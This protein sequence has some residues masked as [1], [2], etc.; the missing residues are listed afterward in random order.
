MRVMV[1]GSTGWLGRYA[2]AELRSGCEVAGPPRSALDLGTASVGETAGVL[3]AFAPDAVVNCAGRVDGDPLGLAAVN[4]R[5]PAVL[6]AAMATAVP[7]A[8]LVHLGSAAEYGAVPAGE[9]VTEGTATSPQGLYGASKLT[10]TLAVAGAGLDAV[11]L[12]VFNVVGPGAP[13]TSLPG[14]LA[15]KLRAAAPGGVVRTGPLTASRDYVDPRDVARAVA[16][17]VTAP[18]VPPVLNIAGGR[19]TPVRVLAGGLADAAGFRGRIEEVADAGSRRSGYVPWQ[20]ADIALAAAALGWRP[21]IPLAQSVKD[22]WA[23]G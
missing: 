7:R 4:A 17:A 18:R 5:G 16:L 21:E 10:G 19:A 8:R 23:E 3:A 13:A 15:A 22:L 14:T 12:R 6:C 9:P 1:L 2:T 11:V 20:Q